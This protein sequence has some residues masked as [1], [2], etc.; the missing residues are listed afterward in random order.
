MRSVAEA[1]FDDFLP[2]DAMEERSVGA[3]IDEFVPT[4][5]VFLR[6]AAHADRDDRGR[7][8]GLRGR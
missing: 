8:Y 4:A 3:S 7:A 2:P 5:A 6:I 1:F